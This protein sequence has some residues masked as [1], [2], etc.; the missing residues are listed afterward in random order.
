MTKIAILGTGHMGTPIARRLLG[1]GHPVT[2]W[3]RTAARAE[4]LV[5]AGARVAAT[6]AEAVAG[7]ELVIV[8]LTDAAAVDAALIGSGAAGA[9]DRSAVVVQMSTIGP[10]E[11][12]AIVARLPAGV[13]FVDAPVGGSVGAAASGG[14]TVFAGG[15]DKA[16]ER[17][18]PVLRE[19]GAVRRCGGVGAGSA[20]K[21]VINTAMIASMAALRDTLL[22]AGAAGIDRGTALDVLSTGP[23]RDAIKRGTA[24]GVSFA[25]ALAAKDVRLATAAVTGAPVAAAVLGVLDAAPDQRADLAALITEDN[26]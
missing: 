4:P 7:A 26:R 21:L 2:V 20:L 16:V 11:T 5:D 1:R 22:V 19:L 23:L 10:D 24:T 12:R 9:L 17:A 14:L 3:N 18:E 13:A 8:M 25:I 6:P 15:D